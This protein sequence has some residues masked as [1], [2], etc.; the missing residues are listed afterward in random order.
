MQKRWL[1]IVIVIALLA[2][3]GIVI[4]KVKGPSASSEPAPVPVQKLLDEAAQ[5]EADG[6]QVKAKEAYQQIVHEHPD[7]DKVEDIQKKVGELNI[8][9]LFSKEMTPQSEMYQVQPGDSLAKLA[10][11]YGTTAELIKRSNNLK[12]DVIR[13]GQNL[14]IWKAPFTIW[15]SKSQ[16]TLILKSGDEVVKI[17]PVSTGRDNKDNATPTGTFKIATRI[18]HPVWFKPGGQPV[19]PESPQN[20]L[21][22][23]W[24]GFAEDPHYGIHG[25]IHPE[26][27]G[28]RATAGCVRMLNADVEELFDIVPVGTKVTI[29]E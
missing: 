2:T 13:I 16:N 23:R 17:Y 25:T 1:V 15:V 3:V 6:D 12:S 19:P 11:Q 9:I 20:E 5:H 14:R 10:K 28:K 24:M 7:Y 4:A 18:P 8:N 27:I 21:G 22:T 29:Q 26:D